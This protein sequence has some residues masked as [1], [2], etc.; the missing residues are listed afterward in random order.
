MTPTLWGRIQTRLFL[1]LTIGLLITIYFMGSY[2]ITP[3]II[4]VYAT[5]IGFG[6]DF[7]YIKIQKGRWDRDFPF[8]YQFIG[9]IVEGIFLL[10]LI[11][12]VGLSGISTNL[13]GSIF[14]AHYGTVF[15]AT[16]FFLVGPMRIFFPR[17]R[18]KG[19]EFG[20]F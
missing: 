3:L 10:G 20:K 8:A 14:I 5:I 9:G 6:W 13:P 18:F 7:I 4:L 17:W 19:A 11:W 12:T 15:L 2:G 16:F 1:M